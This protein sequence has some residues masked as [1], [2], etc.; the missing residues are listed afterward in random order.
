VVIEKVIKQHP[1]VSKKYLKISLDK[2][3][4]GKKSKQGFLNLKNE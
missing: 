2:Y 3:A 1:I 4:F